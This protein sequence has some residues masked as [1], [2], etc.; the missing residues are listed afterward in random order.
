MHLAPIPVALIGTGIGFAC[1]T[2]GLLFESSTDERPDAGT[3][4]HRAAILLLLAVVLAYVQLG[5]GG[6]FGGGL[7]ELLSFDSSTSR[8]RS[9]T[10]PMMWACSAAALELFLASLWRHS[11]KPHSNS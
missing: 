7:S 11:D 5:L 3:L 8:G 9:L 6:L 1:C 4:R 10:V 2:C